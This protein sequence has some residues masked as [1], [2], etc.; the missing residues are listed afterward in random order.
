MRDKGLLL[1]GE[2]DFARGLWQMCNAR[3]PH[4]SRS[5]AEEARFRFLA[6]SAYARFLLSRLGEPAY[7]ARVMPR[8]SRTLRASE[9]HVG[10]DPGSARSERPDPA[11]R[12]RRPRRRTPKTRG[13][14]PGR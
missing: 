8:C 9:H 12:V 14:A 4:A 2:Y 10:R 13:R 1:D 6:I 11:R 3:G 5:D 7:G